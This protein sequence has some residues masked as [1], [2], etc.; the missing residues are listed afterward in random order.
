MMSCLAFG[1]DQT[2]TI[3][4]ERIGNESRVLLTHFIGERIRR[5]EHTEV[6]ER[7]FFIPNTPTGLYLPL[8]PYLHRTCIRAK[9]VANCAICRT[10]NLCR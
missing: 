1:E 7:Q 8:N 10:L 2:D 3:V 9:I 5:E 6:D 4:T